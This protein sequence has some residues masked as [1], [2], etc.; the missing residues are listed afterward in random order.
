MMR[1]V[2]TTRPSTSDG[3]GS[4]GQRDALLHDVR[5]VERGA[6]RRSQ[7]ASSTSQ[8]STMP[9]PPY[10]SFGLSTSRSRFAL[11]VRQQVDLLAVPNR[12]AALLDHARPRDVR[13]DRV[14][15][16]AVNMSALR[17]S[18]STARLAFLCRILQRNGFTMQTAPSRTART[19]GWSRPPRSTSS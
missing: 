14:A 13:R 15:L 17:S 2:T 11:D 7:P 5:L 1:S 9:L 6:H 12:G 19:T 18:L 3:Y 8:P 4:V 10:S 16:A